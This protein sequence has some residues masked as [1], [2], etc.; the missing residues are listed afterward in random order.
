MPLQVRNPGYPDL[1]ALLRASYVAHLK[2]TCRVKSL[3]QEIYV[4]NTQEPSFSG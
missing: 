4:Y 1:R 2:L 3:L